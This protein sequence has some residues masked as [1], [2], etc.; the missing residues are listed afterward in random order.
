[1]QDPLQRGFSLLKYFL[2][3]SLNYRGNWQMTTRFFFFLNKETHFNK[4][5]KKVLVNRGPRV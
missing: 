5:K 3:S 4:K 2:S 1:M